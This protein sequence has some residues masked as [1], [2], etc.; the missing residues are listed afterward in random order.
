MKKKTTDKL[1]KK[2]LTLNYKI[3][4]ILYEIEIIL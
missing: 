1:K 3:Y 2:K 4:N